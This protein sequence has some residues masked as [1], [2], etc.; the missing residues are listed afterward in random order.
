LLV[1]PRGRPVEQSAGQSP[2][3][4]VVIN[5]GGR[6]AASRRS[7]HTTFSRA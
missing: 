1:D 4:P 6:Y 2:S 5:A 3:G 7:N